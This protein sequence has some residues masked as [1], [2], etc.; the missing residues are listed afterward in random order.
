[1]ENKPEDIIPEGERIDPEGIMEGL[2]PVNI[3]ALFMP[4]IWGPAHGIWLTILYYPIWLFADNLL[5][6]AYSQPSAMSIIM[7]VI[8]VIILAAVT[9]VFARAGQ[10]YACRRALTEQGKTKK[11][12]I[13]QQKKWAIAMV[14]VAL[15]FIGLATWY[16]LTI[17]PTVGA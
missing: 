4:A 11:Q 3:G 15:I 2:L 10:E 13:A 6:S 17:R 9:I 7:A 1:M 5:Y 8:T 12:Y 14:I 16:N